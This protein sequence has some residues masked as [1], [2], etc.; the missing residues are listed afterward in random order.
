MG[1]NVTYPG[2]G[3]DDEDD[4]WML[5]PLR[6]IHGSLILLQSTKHLVH[7]KMKIMMNILRRAYLTL[8]SSM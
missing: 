5:L 1:I 4:F 2:E 7:T 3:G 8:L 6:Y